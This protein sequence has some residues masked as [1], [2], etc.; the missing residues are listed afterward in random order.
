MKIELNEAVDFL[1]AN[2]KFLILMHGNPDGD[3]LGCGSALCGALQRMGKKARVLCPDHVPARFD[4]MER[5]YEKQEFEP[6]TIVTVDVADSKLLGELQSI[7]DNADLCIDHHI[8]NTEYAKRLLLRHDYAAA[9]ELVYEVI[10]ALEVEIDVPLANCIYTGIA[11]DTGC[12][13]FSNT[14]PQSHIYAAELLALGVEKT[15]INY[16]MFEMK[17]PGR[18][19]L[20]QEVLRTVKYFA[21]GH[22]A[23]IF[24]S[25][26][27]LNSITDIDSDD[28]GALAAL[29]RQIQGVDIGLSIKE[30]KPGLYKAS[31]RS[32]ERINVAEI[33]RA[34]GGGGHDRASGC[35]FEDTT[36]EQAE[37]LITDA[38]VEACR[39][40][41]LI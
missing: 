5:A 28:V 37:K 32:S 31:L 33:A 15:M 41:G 20:E 39:K 10:K 34:F 18:I 23:L 22:V 30:K 1:K 19:R 6:E 40:A 8:S 2:D 36:Y 29:P 13:K 26:D 21:D 27:M 7:G 11:T 35:S 24:T 4:Y 12:F 16:I 14:S 3:T 17:T 38:C 25:L 9:A